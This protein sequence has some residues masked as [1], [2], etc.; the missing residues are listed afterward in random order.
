MSVY[1]CSRKTMHLWSALYSENIFLSRVCGIKVIHLSVFVEEDSALSSLGFHYFVVID[2]STSDPCRGGLQE[3]PW[4]VSLDSS[5]VDLLL[6]QKHFCNVYWN[7][8]FREIRAQILVFSQ[9]WYIICM[10]F[11]HIWWSTQR[12]FFFFEHPSHTKKVYVCSVD[13]IIKHF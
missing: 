5:D 3:Q 7:V 6:A 13:H 4:F 8:V 9:A 2:F 11:H 12:S 1:L 10:W